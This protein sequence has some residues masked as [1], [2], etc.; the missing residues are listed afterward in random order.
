MLKIKIPKISIIIPVYNEAKTAEQVVRAIHELPIDKEIVVVDDFSKDGSREILQKLYQE[1]K[2]KL[3]LHAHNK[4]KGAAVRNA[5][6]HSKGEYLV[7][8]DADMELDP[9]DILKMMEMIDKDPSIDMV[10]GN[11]ILSGKVNLVTYLGKL[12]TSLTTLLLYGRAIK[13]PL[14]A[15]KLCK[16]TKFRSLNIM[17]EK[18]GLETEWAIKA[19]KKG[20]NIKQ[21]DVYYKPRNKKEG[22]KISLKDGVDIVL[23]LVKL[24]FSN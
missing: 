12:V 10:I 15:Y 4:G 11:R 7:V 14:C 18:F 23:E 24:R 13:D 17:S 21:A 2:F 20:W 9:Q 1:L 16:L 3:I 8:M 19:V 6:A 5:A 22:K